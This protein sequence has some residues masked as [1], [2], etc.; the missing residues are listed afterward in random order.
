MLMDE[1]VFFPCLSIA[2]MYFETKQISSYLKKKLHL[3]YTMIV[4]HMVE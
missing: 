3:T 1:F 2:F 4:Y